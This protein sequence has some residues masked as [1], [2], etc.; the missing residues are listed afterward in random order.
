MDSHHTSLSQAMPAQA[1]GTSE[2]V[3]V[4]PP[5]PLSLDPCRSPT[6]CCSRA[7]CGEGEPCL[8][9]CVSAPGFCGHQWPPCLVPEDKA[10]RRNHPT[11]GTHAPVATAR[12]PC[13][14]GGARS[15]T[16]TPWMPSTPHAARAGLGIKTAQQSDSSEGRRRRDT[17]NH[18]DS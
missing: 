6:G 2:I 5:L 17:R 3:A 18:N 8:P 10:S 4:L 14:R 12:R 9:A 1:Q 13:G 16:S 7:K 15:H 11:L